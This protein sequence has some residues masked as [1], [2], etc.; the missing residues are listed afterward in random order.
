MKR[1]IC[2][3][4]LCL[5]VIHPLA[6]AQCP[7]LSAT[8]TSTSCNGGANGSI[9]LT[10]SG[11]TANLS[12]PGLLISEIHTDPPL[13]DSPKEWVELVATRTI[14]FAQTPYTVFFSNN[15]TATSKGWVEGNIP[16]PPPRNS[17]YA[18]QISTGTVLAGDVVYVG[19]TSM[20]P[21]GVRLR[22]KN[23]ST[24]N[25][26]GGIGGCRRGIDDFLQWSQLRWLVGTAP[27]WFFRAFGHPQRSGIGR[28]KPSKE[29]GD[30]DQCLNVGRIQRR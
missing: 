1:L 26:D 18:F 5:I 22:Q 20:D 21:T 13:A 25:G 19:G 16:S 14:N 15:G 27:A 11:D 2:L 12:N 8:V 9:L 10:V 3:T 23:T 6:F 7:T 24:E 4:W 30:V 17:T 28:K 29:G